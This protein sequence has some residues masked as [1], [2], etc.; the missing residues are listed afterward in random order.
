M[1][2]GENKR[3][4]RRRGIVSAL[5]VTLS[6]LSQAAGQ[7]AQGQPRQQAEQ[8][9][10]RPAPSRGAQ[11]PQPAPPQED[12]DVVRITSNLI[13]VDAVVLDSHGRQVTDLTADDFELLED[14]RAQVITNF[15]YVNTSPD[16]GTDSNASARDGAQ[17]AN[18]TRKGVT[19]AIPVPPARLRPGS[20]RRTIAF[21]VDDLGLSFQATAYVRNF[22]KDF[23]K[24][25][26]RAGDL[27]AVV[28]TSAGVGALQQFTGD[29]RLVEQA[30]ERVRFQPGFRAPTG[31][32]AAPAEKLDAEAKGSK[33]K[34]DAGEKTDSAEKDGA[35]ASADSPPDRDA[36]FTVGTLGALNYVLRGAAGLPGRKSVVL[37][38]GTSRVF[39]LNGRDASVREYLQRMADLANRASASVYDLDAADLTPDKLGSNLGIVT[40]IPSA[41]NAAGAG[42]PGGS[43]SAAG[44]LGASN[45]SPTNLGL[46]EA[47]LNDKELNGD[48]SLYETKTALR[49]LAK[50][51]GGAKIFGAERI[52]EDQK[53][54]YLIGYR[55]D[56]KTFDAQRAAQKFHNLSVRVKRTGLRVRYR[57]GF[58]SAPEA[59][60]AALA[61]TTSAGRLFRALTSPLASGSIG[62]SLTPLF[63]NDAQ[64][65]SFVRALIHVDARGLRFTEEA[66]G[67]RKA[68][69]E[70]LAVTL[71]ETGKPLDQADGTETVRVSAANFEKLRNNGLRYTLKV[72]VKSPG[73]YQLR[74]AVLDAATEQ[75]GSAN[76]LIEV[77][78]LGDGRLALS[79]IVLS[80]KEAVASPQN[81]ATPETA[82]A[83]DSG[84]TAG[85]APTD[86][87]E[88]EADPSVRR[89]RP[90]ME[91]H[92]D[93]H[94]YNAQAD[95]AGGRP[96]LQTQVRL[97]RDD[98]RPA[99]EGK[100][101]PFDTAQ[102]EDLKRLVAG[103]SIKLNRNAAPGRYVL[104]VVV[105]DLL[106]GEKRRV[107]T[108]WIDFELTR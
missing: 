107:A 1:R 56:D 67:T 65:G 76:E 50:Q 37:I 17:R 74:V 8:P 30:V 41:P 66:D 38:S 19:A 83:S 105:T 2:D 39:K 63:G 71:G 92:Y 99:Y 43:A 88:L 16:A 44:A 94:I 70:I 18:P 60:A 98:G 81:A 9:Q 72:P 101:A 103:G 108:Q 46:A 20:A 100:V 73:A 12:E 40:S 75:V 33:D 59:D 87:V 85:V 28:R 48:R 54:Y 82:A 89:L 51:T 78:D 27:V 90:G 10:Q 58:Y 35:Q 14:G 47:L 4:L 57:T 31:A 91:L 86:D 106:A 55:P 61:P 45:Q 13:Q 69:V 25:Q 21:V 23:V 24:E 49:Y 34:K 15:S 3:A 36:L 11:T 22:L 64:T 95:P 68:V 97:F 77:P 102:Q 96:R 84:P 6:I 93:F 104:Q 5:V 42:S 79:G 53:G 62:L 29:P 26:M 52:V 80:G 32:F 7:T